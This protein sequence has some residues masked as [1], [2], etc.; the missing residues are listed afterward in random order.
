MDELGH[1][2]LAGAALAGDQ[3]GGAG[4][5]GGLDRVAQGTAPGR[6]VAD[7]ELPDVA[8]VEQL[9]DGLPAAQALRDCAANSLFTGPGQHVGGA[10]S[11]QPPAVVAA[12][13]VGH[14]E[15]E[16]AAR[17]GARRTRSAGPARPGRAR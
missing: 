4:E 15:H 3:H 9:V 2:L 6:A 10:G 5:P 13:V 11:Q 17:A 1:P 14:T 8:A 7:Q 16:Q 12:P